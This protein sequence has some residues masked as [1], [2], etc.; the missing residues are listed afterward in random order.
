MAK[1][2]IVAIEVG[3]SKMTGVAG[4]KNSDG[5]ITVLA[6]VTEDPDS[7]IRK[8]VVYKTDKTTQC[9]INIVS[10]IETAL[11][12]AITGVYVGQG[13]QSVRSVKN[14]IVRDLPA[15]TIV[16]DELVNGIMDTNRDMIYPDYEILDVV[17]HEY[18]VGPQYQ[19]DPVGIQ[20]ERIEGNFLNVLWR[21]QF[22]RNLKKC[23]DD[24]GINVVDMYPSAIVLADSVL[25]EAEKRTGCLLIDLGAETTT[26]SVYYRDILRHLA[27]IPLGSNNVTKDIES[28]Q[29]DEDEA[30]NLKLKYACAYTEDKDYDK[31]KK[32]Q[33]ADGRTIDSITFIEV[34]EARVKEIVENV[35]FQIPAEYAGKLLGGIILTGGGSNMPNIEKAFRRATGI[36]RVRTATT[37]NAA[38]STSNV[39]ITLPQDGTT[40]IP[41]GLIMK[42]NTNCAGE[43]IEG[44]LFGPDGK[45]RAAA[46]KA[47]AE[48]KAREAAEAAEAERKAREEAEAEAERQR[49]LEEEKKKSKIG[50]AVKGFLK[51]LISADPNESK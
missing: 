46:N 37:V 42:G 9:L 16:T 22:A 35:A 28:L 26:V 19:R 33:L 29:I 8:G 44:S 30:E 38:V 4:K 34:V 2:F 45:A 13:G 41:L 50:K 14:T 32:I 40:C 31:T 11:K 20:A 6:A 47:E 36:D 18:K 3:S 24:A 27:V 48:R 1:D 39:R 49:Q 25:T 23:F 51:A 7:C 17:T 15:D 21:R 10:K 12:T 43:P 5:S